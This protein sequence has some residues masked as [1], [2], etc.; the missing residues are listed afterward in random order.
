MRSTSSLSQLLWK[1]SSRMALNS[2]TMS[3]SSSGNTPLSCKH[4]ISRENPQTFLCHE[5]SRLKFIQQSS[6]FV[7]SISPVLSF[8]LPIPCFS[9]IYTAVFKDP[10]TFQHA[11][12]LFCAHLLLLASVPQCWSHS[13]SRIARTFSRPDQYFCLPVHSSYHIV[14]S[15]MSLSPFAQICR[16]VFWSCTCS[17][18][19]HVLALPHLI[20]R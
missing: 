18:H 17:L 1:V 16:Q 5:T 13:L 12:V 7:P 3:P 19:F 4:F 8:D 9:G 20:H 6:F 14:S 2:L 15:Q 11:S 10:N